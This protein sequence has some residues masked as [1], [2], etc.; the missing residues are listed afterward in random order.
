MSI[1]VGCHHSPTLTRQAFVQWL[2]DR[3]SAG[4][5]RTAIGRS[6][7]VSHEAV[8]QWVSGRS[9]VSGTVLLLAEHLMA[10]PR[11]LAAGMPGVDGR[12]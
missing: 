1:D 6:L 10:V 2:N 7:G 11:D 9:G 4:E 12:R 8:R 5:T 3:L